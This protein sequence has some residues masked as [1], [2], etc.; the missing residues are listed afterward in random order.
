MLENHTYSGVQDRLPHRT[1]RRVFLRAHQR[2][3]RSRSRVG[4]EAQRDAPHVR[5]RRPRTRRRELRRN[6]VHRLVRGARSSPPAPRSC[7]GAARSSS[8]GQAPRSTRLR[9]PRAYRNPRQEL[10]TCPHAN[11]R[12]TPRLAGDERPGR[13]RAAHPHN[14]RRCRYAAAI[15]GSPRRRTR[16]RDRRCRG[17]AFVVGGND[18]AADSTCSNVRRSTRPRLRPRARR[19]ARP[20]ALRGRDPSTTRFTKRIACASGASNAR[21]V[22]ISSLVSADRARASAAAR[23]SRTT[24]FRGR[25]RES[26]TLALAA[27]TR[28]SHADASTTRRRCNGRGSR[29]S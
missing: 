10:K 2:R 5:R 6:R 28:R 12:D 15:L 22:R 26:G 8:T 21:P 20:C 19:R 25:L 29:R 13:T 14:W 4:A 23:R 16:P 27:T 11:C 9:D 7:S 3:R 17:P 24:G 1:A 18:G